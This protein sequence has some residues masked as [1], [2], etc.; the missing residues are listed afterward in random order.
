MGVNDTNIVIK[1]LVLGLVLADYS[2]AWAQDAPNAETTT[3]SKSPVGDDDFEDFSAL[4]LEALLNVE[5]DTGSGFKQKLS[6]IPAVVDVMTR[7]RIEALGVRDIYELMWRLTGVRFDASSLYPFLVNMPEVR[8]GNVSDKILLIVDDHPQLDELDE[9]YNAFAIP[10]ESIE[11][12]EFLRGPAAVLYGSSS[13][14]GVLRIV[15]RKGEKTGGGGSLLGDPLGQGGELSAHG[16]VYSDSGLNWRG[17]VQARRG[18]DWGIRI[19]RDAY[20]LAGVHRNQIDYLS[21]LSTIRNESWYGRVQNH[22]MTGHML[23]PQ[24]SLIFNTGQSTLTMNGGEIGYQK[25]FDRWLLKSR[26]AAEIRRR[27]LNAGYFPPPNVGFPGRS[28]EETVTVFHFDGFTS[29]YALSAGYED[30]TWRLL[31]GMQYRFFGLNN[32]KFVFPSDG[33]RNTLFPIDDVKG[34]AHDANLF[35]QG[36]YS[37]VEQLQLLA[38]GRVNFYKNKP[39]NM[40]YIPAADRDPDIIVSPMGRAAVVWKAHERLTVKTLY[41]RS[42]RLPTLF[43]MYTEITTLFRANTKLKPETMD[44]VEL[45]FDARPVDAVFVRVNG[46]YN[47]DYDTIETMQDP[48]PAQTAQFYGN[49]ADGFYNYG[50]EGYGDWHPTRWLNPFG[51]IVFGEGYNYR[52]NAAGDRI[53]VYERDVPRIVANGGL[54]FKALANDALRLTPFVYHRGRSDNADPDTILNATARYQPL[55]W[56]EVSLHANNI[57]G[58]EYYQ[59]Y[60][61]TGGLPP[62]EGYAVDTRTLRL[63]VHAEF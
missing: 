24:S 15:T 21:H 63:G 62:I 52:R 8:G 23:G 47:R 59:P 3:A 25:A 17:D 38:G 10:I 34:F 39:K 18:E 53:D 55:A 14:A 29:E 32:V 61:Q 50:V 45:S 48:D 51:S 28:S 54:T 11:R 2:G 12:V 22:V 26:V 58:R 9:V 31:T 6:D 57:L 13:M 16:Q 1:L 49:N 5:I 4:N 36:G 44:T 46:F 60:F 41:G 20:G 40:S 42:F 43:E 37:P 19:D 27:R 56:L 7:E 30:E 35:V 33:A